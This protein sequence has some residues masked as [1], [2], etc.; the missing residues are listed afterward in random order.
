M[1]DLSI[2]VEHITAFLYNLDN[3]KNLITLYITFFY[4]LGITS[5]FGVKKMKEKKIT[6]ESESASISTQATPSEQPTDVKGL[7]VEIT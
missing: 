1:Y 6:E 5:L 2:F 7:E 3:H 4:C